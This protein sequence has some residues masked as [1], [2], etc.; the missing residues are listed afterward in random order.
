[1]FRQG[2]VYHFVIQNKRISKGSC[3]I[4]LLYI[5]VSYTYSITKEE[6]CTLR[7]E[8][9]CCAFFRMWSS[10]MWTNGADAK[11]SRGSNTNCCSGRE[12]LL[13]ILYMW[14]GILAE[15]LSVFVYAVM[16]AHNFSAKVLCTLYSSPNTVRLES[17]I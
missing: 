8:I 11:L 2:C 13:H 14:Y 7:K 6:W 16:P 12:Y 9:I 17:G 3:S 5:V 4:S 1:M 15:S 10:K